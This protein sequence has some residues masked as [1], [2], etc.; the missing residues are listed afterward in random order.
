MGKQETQQ[1]LGCLAVCHVS[2]V[3][4]KDVAV[5]VLQWPFLARGLA[6]RYSSAGH[7]DSLH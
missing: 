7:P 2:P 1:R 3:A 5:V 6:A 4:G